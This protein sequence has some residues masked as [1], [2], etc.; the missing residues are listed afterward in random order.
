M[1]DMGRYNKLR[2]NPDRYNYDLATDLPLRKTFWRIAD[3]RVLFDNKTYYMLAVDVEN[4]HLI[5][6]WYGR[7]VG[8]ELLIKIAEVDVDTGEYHFIRKVEEPEYVMK[9]RPATIGEYAARYIEHEI[10][11]PED[12]PAYKEFVDADKVLEHFRNSSE[13]LRLRFRRL[14]NGEYKWV[15]MAVSKSKDYCDEIPTVIFYLREVRYIYED[16]VVPET[17]GDE[18]DIA[19]DIWHTSE[20]NFVINLSTDEVL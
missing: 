1:V 12:V 15:E 14:L 4:F 2:L 13:P 17:G 19:E 7:E 20:Y 18:K 8:D 10:I 5:N 16:T 3:E 11:H 9:P 6:K